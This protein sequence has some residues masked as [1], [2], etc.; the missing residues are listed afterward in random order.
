MPLL[1]NERRMKNMMQKEG[2]DAIV[3]STA[4]NIQYLSDSTVS[5]YVVLPFEKNLDPFIV[6][7]VAYADKVVDSKTWVKD[8]KYTG[9]FFF[10]Y[11][12]EARMTEFEN[13][14]RAQVSP[15]QK[16][17]ENWYKLQHGGVEG[18]PGLA[19]KLLEGLKERNL[20]KATI[21][22]EESG[23]TV[24]G[25]E[26]LKNKLPKAKLVFADKVFNYSRM[27]KTPH[28]LQLF[29][30]GTPMVERGIKAAVAI[31][32]EGV[33]EQEIFNEY[34]RTVV[35][36]GAGVAY[37]QIV[38]VGHRSIM[39]TCG[40][41]VDRSTRLEK[42][43]MIRFNPNLVLKNHPFHM[44]RTVVLGE[45]KDSKLRL[46][47]K[48]I[49]TGE[50]AELAAIKPGVKASE[51][52]TACENAVKAGGIP[53]FRRH[54]VGHALGLGPAYDQPIL[55]F[56][57]NTV[58]DEGMVFNL[59]PNYFEFGLGGLQLEDTLA[60]TKN[61]YELFTTTSRDLWII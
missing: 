30:E 20:E 10:E 40:V 33:T 35:S 2:L 8:V 32:K 9:T 60:V 43:D 34:K 12:P 55:S 27:V 52:F 25:F 42:G 61:G 36:E 51:I 41:G 19:D 22:L 57:D 56:N 31:A 3:A 44:G 54:H 18:V 50:D 4:E 24:K 29:R 5:G 17:V 59:E 14:M 28:E 53:H 48:A 39:P 45:P 11:F 38:E 6:T 13:R 16:D 49:L 21:G 15:I 37:N 58:L 46:Y 23:T 47:Y 7:W 26:S 1:M